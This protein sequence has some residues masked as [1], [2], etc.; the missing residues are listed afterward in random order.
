MVEY[1]LL[2][3]GP[4]FHAIVG[5]VSSFVDS[6]NWFIVGGLVLGFL[7]LRYLFTPRV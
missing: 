2:T 6:V 4:A 7:T 1:A 5:E 3:A